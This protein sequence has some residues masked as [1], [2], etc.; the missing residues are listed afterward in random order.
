MR[1]SCARAREREKKDL[2]SLLLSRT[3]ILF[4]LSFNAAKRFLPHFTFIT[5]P[6][7]SLFHVIHGL[8]PRFAGSRVVT[9]LAARIAPSRVYRR[10]TTD[11]HGLEMH[12]AGEECSL[13][14]GGARSM[15]CVLSS[16]EEMRLE[17]S[18]LRAGRA[19]LRNAPRFQ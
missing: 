13:G 17:S 19:C 3:R 10:R 16:R 7:T 11:T 14:H 4:F 9:L 12:L 1:D 6:Q 2:P 18:N 8:C 15:V 5:E